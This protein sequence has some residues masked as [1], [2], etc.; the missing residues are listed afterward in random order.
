MPQRITILQATGTD[1]GLTPPP[2]VG[3]DQDEPVAAVEA[4]VTAWFG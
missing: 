4:S 3:I 1:G 2:A